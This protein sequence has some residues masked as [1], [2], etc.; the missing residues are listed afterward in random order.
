MSDNSRLARYVDFQDRQWQKQ[1]NSVSE[2]KSFLYTYLKYFI[3][4]LQCE[5]NFHIL[6]S[7]HLYIILCLCEYTCVFRC[8]HILCT[9]TH[10]YVVVHSQ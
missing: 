9:L 6:D 7:L 2:I 3:I 8:V 10:V 5:N 4:Q 1:S